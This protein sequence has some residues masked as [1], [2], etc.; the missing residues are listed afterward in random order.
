VPRL[1]FQ[2]TVKKQEGKLPQT[3]SSISISLGQTLHYITEFYVG[4]SN[5]F[6]DHRI[7]QA[8]QAKYNVQISRD[9]ADVMSSGRVFQNLGPATANDCSQ[10]VTSHD[11]VM[12]SSEEVEC[13]HICREVIK[14]ICPNSNTPHVQNLAHGLVDP[15]K[16]ITHGSLATL[17]NLAAV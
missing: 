1:K 3:R 4:L 9:G 13:K 16:V 10:T 14:I 17:Q 8:K 11:R 5:N 7:Q 6:K 12:T 15:Y 2:L